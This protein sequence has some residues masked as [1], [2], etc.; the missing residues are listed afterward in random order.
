MCHP[1]SRAPQEP[2]GLAPGRPCRLSAPAERSAAP[3]APVGPRQ[4]HRCRRRRARCSCIERCH[5]KI[6]LGKAV[7]A[8]SRARR[9]PRDR[10]PMRGR[11]ALGQPEQS[12][13][14]AAS[15]D[16]PR[17]AGDSCTF[18]AQ[19][20]PAPAPAGPRKAARHSRALARVPDPEERLSEC[21]GAEEPRAAGP[22][23]ACEPRR[24]GRR[25]CRRRFRL[26]RAPGSRAR[27]AAS[28]RDPGSGRDM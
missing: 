21:R 24:A 1:G 22:P 14:S 7:P 28:P 26:A 5:V 10:A 2:A 13:S 19:G 11:P 16:A 20:W 27:A 25:R 3:A 15:R 17:Y 6:I 9:A 23:P 12:G 4:P 8:R 18:T